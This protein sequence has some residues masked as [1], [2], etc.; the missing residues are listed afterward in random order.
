MQ[1]VYILECSDKTYYTGCTS[2][3]DARLVRHNSGEVEYTKHR[4]PVKIVFYCAFE[5][6]EK[7]LNLRSI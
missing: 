2:N 4:L 6:S 3:L 7:P 5:D 1:I